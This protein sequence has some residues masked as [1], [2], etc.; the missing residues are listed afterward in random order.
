MRP[1]PSC[2]RTV[3]KPS[4][5]TLPPVTSFACRIDPGQTLP[6]KVSR[7]F[8]D[9]HHGTTPRAMADSSMASVTYLTVARD[10]N[11]V[12]LP[13][14]HSHDCAAHE[15]LRGRFYAAWTTSPANLL[16]LCNPR[17][18][19]IQGIHRVMQYTTGILMLSPAT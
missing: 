1:L 16:Q 3:W 8:S 10:Q 18:N 4:L 7:Q 12:P 13:I 14:F 5:A 17:L 19:P 6:A 2:H 15:A 11:F 9:R